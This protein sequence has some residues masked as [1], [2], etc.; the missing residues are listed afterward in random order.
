MKNFGSLF[1]TVVEHLLTR[2]VLGK[3]KQFCFPLF[4]NIDWRKYK[5]KHC[6]SYL[7]SVIEFVVS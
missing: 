2:S 3:N 4:N 6:L 7:E 5:F 1:S